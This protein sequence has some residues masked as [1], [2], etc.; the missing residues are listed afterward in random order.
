MN[1]LQ[2]LI[3]TFSKM[4]TKQDFIKAFE[5]AMGVIDKAL[6][7]LTTKIDARLAKIKD[8]VDG[9]DGK[10]GRDGKNGAPGPRG[11]QGVMGPIGRSIF[12]GKGADGA[13][14]KDGSPDTGD[15][16]VRKINEDT[17]ELIVQKAVEGL[18]LLEEKVK[19]IE[20]RPVGRGGGAKGIG[21]YVNGSKK[22][23]TA[24][25]IN[26]VPGTGI[27]ITYLH[28]YGRNDITI[29]ATGSASLLPITVTGTVDDSNKSF[30][31]ASAPNIVIV[32]GT[33]YRDGHGCAIVGTAITL[34]NPVGTGGDI[35]CL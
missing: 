33:S 5:T 22:L 13:P 35:Y 24:Q 6:T 14:G 12:G 4:L 21:L 26:L 28:T 20:L 16:I 30:T 17:Q 34:D 23:L 7:D 25:T 15:E 8:G 3:E 9:T 2:V 31:A 27:S 18:P 19:Q 29:S 1:E 32:N 10:D 11:P